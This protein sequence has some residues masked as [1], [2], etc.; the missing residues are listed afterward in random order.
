MWLKLK[1][2]NLWCCYVP[3]NVEE[4]K[5]RFAVKFLYF[6]RDF[7]SEF[8]REWVV[9]SLSLAVE[10]VTDA[11]SRGVEVTTVGLIKGI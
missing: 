9:V 2:L 7:E 3:F 4:K 5:M 8:P 6:I 11:L 10:R 1:R